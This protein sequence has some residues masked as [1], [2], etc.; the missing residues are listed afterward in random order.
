MLAAPALEQRP[1]P[2]QTV[3]QQIARIPEGAVHLLEEGVLFADFLSNVQRESLEARDVIGEIVEALI[4]L[5]LENVGVGGVAIFVVRM[6]IGRVAGPALHRRTHAA[7]QVDA[8][9]I[10]SKRR[11]ALSALMHGVG[12]ATLNDDAVRISA[13][14]TTMVTDWLCCQT[15][16]VVVTLIFPHNES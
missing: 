15:V 13:T 6:V 11:C 4:V 1:N 9:M 2:P 10:L 5:L 7:F 8:V 14:T 12:H 16:L 3:L